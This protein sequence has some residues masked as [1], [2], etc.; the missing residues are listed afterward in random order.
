M[1]IT[2]ISHERNPV[3]MEKGENVIC[4]LVLRV[5]QITDANVNA[6]LKMPTAATDLRMSSRGLKKRRPPFAARW[7]E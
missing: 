7:T 6:Q 5:G 2:E 4:M 3:T 1:T